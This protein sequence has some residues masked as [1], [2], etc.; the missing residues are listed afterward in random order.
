MKARAFL[1]GLAAVLCTLPLLAQ[2]IPGGDDVWDSVGGGATEATLSPAQWNTLCGASVGANTAVQLKGFNIPGQGTG[3]TVVRRLETAF[4]PGIGSSATVKIQLQDLSMV[5]DGTN[6][7]GALGYSLRVTDYGNQATG[8]MT[9]AKTSADG[10]TF[11]AKVPVSALIEALDSSG[12]PRGSV[13]VT[14]VLG[15]S[16]SSP[17]SY[18]PPSEAATTAA[19]TATPPWH[20]SVD[21]VTKLP[22]RT[23]RRGNKTL[24]ARHCYQPTPPCPVVKNPV[25]IGANAASG[26]DSATAVGDAVAVEAC[27]VNDETVGTLP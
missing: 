27:S 14:G 1:L 2:D 19:A 21:P 8:A 13:Y 15:D 10:G 22:V 11:T 7:C 3:D 5:N 16:S 24:P 12:T 26:V 4:L 6:P 23:C 20:P 25:A 9:I 18:A 17:W